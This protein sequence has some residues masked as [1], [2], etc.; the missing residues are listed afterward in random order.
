MTN[1]KNFIDYT[2]LY[3]Y[4][5]CKP[6]KRWLKTL[7]EQ[8][9]QLYKSRGSD[10][11]NWLQLI[12]ELPKFDNINSELKDEVAINNVDLDKNKLDITKNILKQ[13]HPWKKGPYNIFGIH[14]D[15]EWRSDW[16][17]DRIKDHIEPLNGKKVLDIGCGNGYHC[18]RMYGAGAELVIGIDPYWLYIAQFLVLKY[19]IGNGANVHLL[20]MGIENL[21]RQLNVFDTVFSLGVLYHRRSPIDHIMQL[22]DCLKKDGELILETLVINSSKNEILV[23]ENRYS[24]M[25]N[26]WFIPTAKMLK[27]WLYR[28]GFKE[29]TVININTTTIEEQRKTEWMTNESLSDFL[30][31]NN[32][33]LTIEGYPAPVRAILKAKRS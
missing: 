11:D 10:F 17:W 19:F 25:R 23:P 27:L 13:F 8:I 3:E 5:K 28:C 30:D 14:I 15:T 31:P 20:P 16:K 7:P 24:K 4:M 22:R 18:W 29:I 33:N 21:P 9:D 26:I 12:N 1:L 32:P 6:L 2:D